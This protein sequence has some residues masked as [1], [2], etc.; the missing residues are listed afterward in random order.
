MADEVRI[1]LLG[2]GVVGGGVARALDEKAEAIARRVG[3][4]VRLARVLVRD[5]ARPRP[6]TPAA[7]LTADA[8]EILHDPAIQ[9]VVEVLGGEQPACGYLLEAI[10]QGKHVVTA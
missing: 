9:V 7:P 10:Q 3:R 6:Y 5:P 1:G 2:L 8:A 4:P